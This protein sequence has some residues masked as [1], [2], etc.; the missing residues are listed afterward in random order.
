MLSGGQSHTRT[1]S[2]EERNLEQMNDVFRR[3]LLIW[4]ENTGENL[5]KTEFSQLIV[6]IKTFTHVSV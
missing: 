6:I 5:L 1:L 3:C 2:P 4:R